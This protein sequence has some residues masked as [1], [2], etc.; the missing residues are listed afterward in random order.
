ME[1]N[2][3]KTSTKE[4]RWESLSRRVLVLDGGQMW[5]LASENKRGIFKREEDIP[6]VVDPQYVAGFT[7]ARQYGFRAVKDFGGKFALGISAGHDWRP[8]LFLRH[9]H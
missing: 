7:W 2:M 9:H 6:L 4:D 3:L 8:R 5:S 1:F